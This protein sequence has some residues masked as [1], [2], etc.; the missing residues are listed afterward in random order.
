MDY[1]LVVRTKRAVGG[2]LLRPAV[3]AVRDGRVAAI[4]DLNPA[5]GTGR[6]L[7]LADDEVL[8]PGLVD[9]HAHINEPGR[10]HW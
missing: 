6:E 10:N 8:I 1:D 3:V 2:G 4:D 9:I 5:A 7:T